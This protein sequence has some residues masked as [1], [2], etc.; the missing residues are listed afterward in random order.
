MFCQD[1]YPY[2]SKAAFYCH[3]NCWR[4]GL[5]A[6]IFHTINALLS[7]RSTAGNPG[8]ALEDLVKRRSLGFHQLT[9]QGTTTIYVYTRATLLI[10]MGP[11]R[12]WWIFA[13]LY[14]S[15]TNK[16]SASAFNVFPDEPC[17][18]SFLC[19]GLKYPWLT[20]QLILCRFLEM[21]YFREPIHPKFLLWDLLFC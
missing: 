11:L 12:N 1:T 2:G 13:L 16:M 18:N 19:M 15:G 5:W 7:L 10:E 3:Q 8:I 17:I 6:A 14:F 20:L 4:K 21:L 9:L